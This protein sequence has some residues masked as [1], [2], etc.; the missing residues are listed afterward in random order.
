MEMEETE[1]EVAS[2]FIPIW[3]FRQQPNPTHTT[4]SR[5]LHTTTNPLK[6]TI[7]SDRTCSG[8]ATRALARTHAVVCDFA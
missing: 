4:T 8:P 3:P 5:S 1:A 6:T 2:V 7:T